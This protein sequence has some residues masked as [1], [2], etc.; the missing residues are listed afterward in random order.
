LLD[1]FVLWR[2]PSAAMTDAEDVDAV[3]RG[4]WLRRARLNAGVTLSDA[5]QTAG[6]GPKSGSTV[7][8]WERGQRGIKV[9]QMKR[10]ALRY[11]V[12]ANLFTDPQETDD[13]R[14]RA[15]IAEA[16]TLALADAAEE[17]GPHPL[18]GGGPGPSRRRRQA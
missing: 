5:A 7:S 11:G 2:L 17:P 10:L 4:Y 15:A 3:R 6:L 8:L 13:E 16:T 12:S 1:Q 14:L 9:H 18:T